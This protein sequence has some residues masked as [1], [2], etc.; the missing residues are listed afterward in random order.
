MST[1][2]EKLTA[3]MTNLSL[4]IKRKNIFPKSLLL[5]GDSHI[6]GLN[7]EIKCH[8]ASLLEEEMLTVQLLR[9][10][11]ILITIPQSFCLNSWSFSL[12]PECESETENSSINFS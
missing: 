8:M 9:F 7:S 11:S 1:D 5:D 6:L 10:L 4:L 12:V 2:S 3:L